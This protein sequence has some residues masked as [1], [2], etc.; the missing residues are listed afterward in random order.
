MVSTA[1][2]L[3][4]ITFSSRFVR[5]QRELNVE[6]ICKSSVQLLGLVHSNDCCSMNC[7]FRENAIKNFLILLHLNNFNKVLIMRIVHFFDTGISKEQTIYHLDFL[8]RYLQR[9]FSL[10]TN[11]FFFGICSENTT[12]LIKMIKVNDR[13][14]TGHII[15]Q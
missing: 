13:N 3:E 12:A 14:F 8:V 7:F 11:L 9:H 4:S 10:L 6:L 5:T 2:V 15:K 1:T